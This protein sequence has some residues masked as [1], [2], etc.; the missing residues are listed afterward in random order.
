MQARGPLTQEVT[1]GV[2][3][4]EILPGVPG[5]IN[6]NNIRHGV[7]GPD[8]EQRLNALLQRDRDRKFAEENAHKVMEAMSHDPRLFCYVGTIGESA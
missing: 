3:G 1:Y 5:T 2:A 7:T 6:Y 8:A 4:S